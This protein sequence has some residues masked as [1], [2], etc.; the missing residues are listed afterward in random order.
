MS[1][2]GPPPAHRPRR[3]RR[4]RQLL[5]RGPGAAHRAVE[6]LDPRRPPRARA[7]RDPRRPGQR[8]PHR[9]GR[10][11]GR[12]GPAA[13]RPSS[14]RSTP[15][16]PSLRD[17]VTGTVRLGVHRHHGPVAGAR[18][19]SRRWTARH[20]KVHVIVVDATTTSLVPQLAADELDLAVVNLPVTDPDVVVEPLFDE[21][22]IL[23]APD[24]HPLADRARVVARRARRAPAAPRAAG[25][26]VPRRARPRGRRRR[27]RA[28]GQGRG[29]RPPPHRH[30]RLPGLRRRHPPGHRRARLARGRAGD[31]SPIDGLERR[32]VGLA[33]RQRGLLSAPVPGAPRRRHRG[34]R[35]RRRGLR[36]ASTGSRRNRCAGG[37]GR[38]AYMPASVP[39]ASDHPGSLSAQITSVGR[40]GRGPGGHLRRAPARAPSPRPTATPSP[41]AAE[42]AARRRAPAARD[43]RLERRRRERRRGRAPRLGHGRPRAGRAARVGCPCCSPSPARSCPARRCSSA[44]PTTW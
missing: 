4:A 20:P 17:E 1:S 25:H 12:A 22:R 29:R 31:G 39:V 10:G 30:P 42:H 24:G 19:C 43:H 32:S 18:S 37:R 13:S 34:G 21:D 35:G 2:D 33:R 44:W 14:T 26:G 9:G 15:T 6:R 16:W 38:S 40:P 7:R 41:T 3:R 23:I 11:G 5:G 36:R 27:R 28:A 8:R